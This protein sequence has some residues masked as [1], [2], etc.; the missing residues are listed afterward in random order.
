MYFI[1]NVEHRHLYLAA[2]NITV[3]IT[4]IQYV[5][6]YIFNI[7]LRATLPL[8]H[9]VGLLG[10]GLIAYFVIKNLVKKDLSASGMIQMAGLVA[11]SIAEIAHLV[12]YY[13]DT[14]HLKHSNFVSIVI[15]DSGC[16]F[17]V[18]CQV[19][20]YMLFISES[21]AQRQERDS[22]THLAYA[23][24]LTNMPN[25][26]KADKML[27]DLDKGDFDYCIISVDLNG[28]KIVNDDFG[29]PAGDKYIK[30]F[31]KILTTTFSDSGFCA[32]IGGDEFLVIIQDSSDKDIEALIGRMTSALNVLNALYPEY[33]RSVATG[34]AY[35]HQC[36]EGSSHEV[37]LMADQ[38]MYENKR[39]MHE[40]LGIHARL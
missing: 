38:Q 5:L 26:A 21:Y 18:M 22:L 37:Y 30:E 4:L 27:D 25:R 31:S 23:D 13:M 15:I 1:Q 39:R 6:H 2:A 10:F 19:S 35:R 29:H 14:L 20:N 33:H 16:L 7:H 34:Y 40:E 32:R 8:Y 36:P 28:L 17:F 24:G 11:F 3:L 9:I 12:M